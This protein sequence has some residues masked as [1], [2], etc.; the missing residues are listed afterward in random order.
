MH[1]LI[2][3]H[4]MMAQQHVNAAPINVQHA[5]ELKPIAHIVQQVVLDLIVLVQ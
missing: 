5:L 3:Q 2:H 1:A 4:S